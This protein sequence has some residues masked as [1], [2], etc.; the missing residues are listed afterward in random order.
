MKVLVFQDWY[1]SI[2]SSTIFFFILRI[3]L[4][5]DNWTKMF[6]I[7]NYFRR[8]VF[9][10]VL[11]FLNRLVF[12]VGFFSF[13][14]IDLQA[15][16]TTKHITFLSQQNRGMQSGMGYFQIFMFAHIASEIQLWWK[17]IE[18]SLEFLMYLLVLQAPCR[19]FFLLITLGKLK[20]TSTGNCCS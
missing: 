16:Y 9:R 6:E 20:H 13:V 5:Y 18:N 7:N 3:H 15:S 8:N 10:V 1:M 12:W 17:L 4:Y 2:L 14:F 11:D 19:H